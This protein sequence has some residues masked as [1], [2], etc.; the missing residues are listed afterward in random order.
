V[1]HICGT[2]GKTERPLKR[3]S[4]AHV[5]ESLMEEEEIEEKKGS[6]GMEGI[7]TKKPS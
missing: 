4:R 5:E 3:R 1:W 7:T 2:H 6:K